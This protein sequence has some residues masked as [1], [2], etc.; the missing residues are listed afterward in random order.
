MSYL[1]KVNK[2]EERNLI[3][4]YLNIPKNALVF[5]SG[6]KISSEKK[7]HNFLRSINEIKNTDVY[8][9]LFG[10][11]EKNYMSEI[12]K[13]ISINSNIKYVKWID[14]KNIFKYFLA[15]DLAVFPGT[16]SV[17][18]QEAICLGI[19]T[20]LKKWPGG[21][22]LDVGGNTIFT[23]SDDYLELKQ[24]LSILIDNPGML[25]KMKYSAEINGEKKFSYDVIAKQVFEF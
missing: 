11:I 7:I 5:I 15:S 22:Y 10:N 12:E 20:I 18:W 14:S 3:R 24:L 17:L 8:V 21:E 19:P 25:S 16:Q 6:G 2:L 13:L 9:I 1:D 4:N 23:Y